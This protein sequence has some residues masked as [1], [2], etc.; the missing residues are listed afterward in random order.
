MN[1][2]HTG[3]IER[4]EIPPGET[5]HVNATADDPRWIAARNG[6]LH[7]SDHN[8]TWP[9]YNG[10]MP[11]LITGPTRVNHPDGTASVVIVTKRCPTGARHHHNTEREAA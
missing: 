9:L 6:D 1:K 3:L 8:G 10:H 2:I 11:V 4:V 7:A 5:V